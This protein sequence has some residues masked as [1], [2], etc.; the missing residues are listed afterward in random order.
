MAQ[1]NITLNQDEILQLLAD[2][3]DSAFKK[4]LQDSL[5]SIL[6]AESA[7]QLKAEPYERSEE[8][9]GS[10]NG[11]RDRPLTTRIG[12][13]ILKVPKHRDGEAFKTF[14]FDNYCRSEAALIVTMAEMCVN[15]VSTR[16]VSQVMETLCGKSFSKSTVSEACK[17]LDEKVKEFRERPLTGEYPFMTIDATYFKVRENSRVISKAFMIAYATNSEGHREIIGFGIYR[18]E[19]KETW[20]SFLKGLKVRGL[21]GVRMITSD[22]HEGIIDAISKQFPD[23]PWQ[24]CQFH[25]S[26]NITQKAPAKYQKG[27]ASELQDMFNC[28]TME[29]ARKRRD[30]IIADYKNVA[31]EAMTCLDEGFESA[32]T[33]M[34]LPGYLH[35][36]FRTSNQIERLNKELK[37]RSKVIGVFPNE[38]S[39]MRLMGA[40]LMERNDHI[41]SLRCVFKATTLQELMTSNLPAKLVKIAREQRQLLA[42]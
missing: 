2:D 4:L 39:L 8:R 32:M 1:L 31:E 9:T 37:R 16:K 14:V 6:R 3:R 20:N 36:Y 27:L 19:S 5:N 17:E 11:F 40:V 26:R 35:K 7:E 34:V 18:N 42:A 25:F 38:D 33:V 22:A 10:R 29:A 12:Q 30:E 21:T 24:R 23:V 15:G 28:K 41:A 13:I